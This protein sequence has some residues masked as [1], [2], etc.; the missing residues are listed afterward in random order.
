VNSNHDNQNNDH[1][2][3]NELPIIDSLISR[4]SQLR[5]KNNSPDNREKVS[6]GGSSSLGELQW[7][8]E[9][10]NDDFNGN[11]QN[12]NELEWDNYEED[13]MAFHNE[14][15]QL[16]YEIEELTQS[17]INDLS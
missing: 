17:T 15:E 7:E 13:T 3:T 16:I 11:E 12:G 10:I 5:S 4:S 1:F 8:N 6:L 14:A 9:I 2:Y